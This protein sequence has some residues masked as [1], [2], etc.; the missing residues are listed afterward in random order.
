MAELTFDAIV[1]GTGQAGPSLASRM[2]HAGMKVAV[3]ER[4]KFGG[5][6]VNNGC[7][8][9]KTMVASAY[10]AQLAR[11]AAEYGVEL[12]GP[13]RVDMKK[14][15]A[16]KDE[17]VARSTHGIEEWMSGLPGGRLLRGHARFVGPQSVQVNDDRLT[18]QRIFLNVGG[19]PLVPKMPGV[20]SVDYLTNVTMMNVDFLPEHLI[21][22]GG[23]YIGLEFGQMFRRFGSRVTVVEMSPRLIARED[24]D[25]SSAMQEIL[26]REGIELR[27]NAR[28]LSLARAGSGVEIKVD[29]QE[30]SP[31]VSGSHLLLAVGRV[32]NTDDLGLDRAGI[33]VDERGYIVV[34]DELRSSNPYVWAL[35]D[36]NGKGAFTHTSY[37]DYEIVADNVLSH[38]GRKVSDR[39]LTYALFTDPPF[40]RVGMS[41]AEVKRAGIR[42]LVGKRPMTRVGRAVEKGESQGFMKILVDADTRHILGAHILGT[43]G[44]EAVHTVLD[45]MYAKLPYTVV[46]HGVRIHPTVSELIPTILG[47]LTPLAG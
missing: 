40:G 7:T 8:P 16:R 21:V 29:C 42:A 32:P 18:A 9:T 35:G 33:E 25:V 23:S 14:V 37:N 26:Q 1:I 46:Q 34:D 45:A 2:A 13:V 31:S 39:I 28:C 43:S 4:D 20:D 5:T 36:C 38:A 19:R 24:E 12:S 44:D 6:C 15:K 30:G 22:V 17:I 27:L 10:A 41:E 47:E 11:R 3:I